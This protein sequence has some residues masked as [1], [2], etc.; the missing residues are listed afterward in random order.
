MMK[1]LLTIL[2]ILFSLQTFSQK[3][4]KN[5]KTQEY[6]YQVIK[7]VPNT[8]K[9]TLFNRANLWHNQNLRST[10]RGLYT[11]VPSGS[12][13]IIDNRFIIKMSGKTGAVYH[14]LSIKVENNKYTCT[15]SGLKYSSGDIENIPF[16]K[17]M[18][19]KKKILQRTTKEIQKLLDSLDKALTG[20]NK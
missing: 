12:I 11:D 14:S 3:I 8:A 15:I 10:S 17:R 7:K 20:N 2:A 5:P 19:R 16:E 1:P 4:S 13:S 9:E 6:Q 18:P